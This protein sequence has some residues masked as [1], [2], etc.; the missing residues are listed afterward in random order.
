[1][2]ARHA[3]WWPRCRDQDRRGN[4]GE[5]LRRRRPLILEL[6]ASLIMFACGLIAVNV[7]PSTITLGR[8]QVAQITGGVGGPSSAAAC[9]RMPAGLS[10]ERRRNAPP[11]RAA[12]RATERRTVAST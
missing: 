9:P 4:A 7:T 11:T 1:M 5:G 2:S 12:F 6:V 10:G 8:R 3:P